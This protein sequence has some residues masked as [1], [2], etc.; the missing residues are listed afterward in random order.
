MW[1]PWIAILGALAAVALAGAR[2]AQAIPVEYRISGVLTGQLGLFVIDPVRLTDAP[3][4][5]SI[6]ADTDTAFRFGSIPG[7]GSAY[8]NDAEAASWTVE[9]LGTATS[10]RSQIFALPGIGD[11]GFGWNGEVFPLNTDDPAERIFRF[12]NAAF[13]LDTRYGRLNSVV[14]PV[15]LSLVTELRNPPQLLP[16]YTT[17]VLFPGQRSLVLEELANLSYSVVA[18]PEPATGALLLLGIAGL[19][20]E[21]TAPRRRRA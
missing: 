16:P 3:F 18:V 14:P 10:D 13:A 1:N 21:R 19:G 20:L 12:G 15:P 11:V 17:T 9:G 6:V 2:P 5:I 4:E 7:V 8:V